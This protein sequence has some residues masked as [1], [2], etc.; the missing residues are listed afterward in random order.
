MEKIIDVSDCNGRI[1]WKQVAEHVSFAILRITKKTGGLDKRFRENVQG[2]RTNGVGFDVYKYSYATSRVGSVM[3]AEKVV[4]ALQ[5][6]ECGAETTVWWD[7]E[8]KSLRGI[9]KATLTENILAAKE[10]I[11]DAGYTFG[12]YCNKDW[13][14]N[15]LDTKALNERYWI[16]RY[17]S[18]YTMQLSDEPSK[19][20]KPTFVKNLVGWQ[21]TSKGRCPGISGNVDLSILYI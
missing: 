8:D 16:A 12:I 7:V 11:T 1:D 13:Y 3:E 2:C 15:V 17:P 19:R 5:S 9:G 10:V 6:V 20:Y 21:Y 4:A 18:T 14:L